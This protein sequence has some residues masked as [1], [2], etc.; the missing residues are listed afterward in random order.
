MGSILLQ[1][2]VGGAATFMVLMRLYGGRAKKAVLALLGREPAQ[3]DQNTHA[4]E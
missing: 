2:A 3:A 4:P 1:G